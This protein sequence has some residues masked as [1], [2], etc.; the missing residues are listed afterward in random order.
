[1]TPNATARPRTIPHRAAL[2]K[3]CAAAALCLVA[4]PAAALPGG[5][6]AVA[7]VAVDETAA[8]AAEA[9]EA[10]IADAHVRAFRRLARRLVPGDRLAEVPELPAG[11]VAPLVRGFGIDDE[12]ASDVRY[13]ASMT[14]RFRRDG[15]RRLLRERGIRFAET[16]SRPVLVLPVHGDAGALR[17]WER[18]APW[19]DAWR[20]LPPSDGLV[21]M[22]LPEGSLADVRDLGAE[23]AVAG[24][25]RR[26]RPVAER[27]GAAWTAVA[28]LRLRTDLGARRRTVEVAIHR[29]GGD[30]PREPLVVRLDPGGDPAPAFDAAARAAA[31]AL[32]ED[33]KRRNLLRFGRPG[34][35][36]ARLALERLADWVAVR[37]RLRSV[38]PLRRLQLV[39]VSRREAAVRMEFY[40][41]VEQ[42]RLALAQRDLA[43]EARADSWRLGRRDGARR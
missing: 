8:T 27:H 25:L 32:E 23:R 30:Q 18:P 35:I 19:L 24:D 1:M 5:V 34:R 3:P 31:G 22:I 42:L 7:G 11:R 29:F 28:V 6:Y 26:L 10:A 39:A 2:L 41:T 4:A 12:K 17:L 16:A 33:W 36:V 14:F 13:I 9:R 40:G 38:A 37:E 21:P 20:R 15:V 43:L